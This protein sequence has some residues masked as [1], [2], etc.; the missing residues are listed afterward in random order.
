VDPDVAPVARLSLRRNATQPL[1]DADGRAFLDQ[2]DEPMT[3]AAH[4]ESVTGQRQVRSPF[5]D[6]RR[7]ELRKPFRA[8]VS[9]D[10]DADP[11]SYEAMTSPIPACTRRTAGALIAQAGLRSRRQGSVG[12]PYTPAEIQAEARRIRHPDLSWARMKAQREAAQAQR[13][14]RAVPVSLS[15]GPDP[16]ELLPGELRAITLSGG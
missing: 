15:N 14:R 12:R 2:S 5:Y 4:V 7:S 16:D 1:I 11:G 10:P 13:Q 9:G 8:N 6:P 3:A